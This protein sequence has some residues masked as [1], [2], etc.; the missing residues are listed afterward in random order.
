[1]QDNSLNR[2]IISDKQTLLYWTRLIVKKWI[3]FEHLVANNYF[4]L[5]EFIEAIE[6]LPEFDKPSYFGLPENIERSSQRMESSAVITALKILKRA[7]TKASKFDKDVWA[8]ELGPVLNLWKKLNTVNSIYILLF[9][10]NFYGNETM[11]IFEYLSIFS[12]IQIWWKIYKFY[13]LLQKYCQH[14]NVQ[15]LF[16]FEMHVD[17]KMYSI[18]YTLKLEFTLIT[19]EWSFVAVG[20]LVSGRELL[21]I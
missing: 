5:K 20:K 13:M 7:D 4:V 2:T 12:Q 18:S 11:K 1:M 6:A 8:T 10:M 17:I 21:W 14:K 19:L 3:R 16:Y 9:K 15:H